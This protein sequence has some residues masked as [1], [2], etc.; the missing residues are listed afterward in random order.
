[1]FYLWCEPTIR[2][3][4]AL[5]FNA[6]ST[7]SHCSFFLTFLIGSR[8]LNGHCSRCW[9]TLSVSV[10]FHLRTGSIDGLKNQRWNRHIEIS[11]VPPNIVGFSIANLVWN[12]PV[13]SVV[14]SDPFPL[15][16]DTALSIKE[17]ATQLAEEDARH[18]QVAQ[19]GNEAWIYDHVMLC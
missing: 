11:F 8:M 18:S 17:R 5:L 6:L 4:L 16:C 9:A 3:V 14:L 7:L 12:L 13:V 15:E 19:T 10:N 1:M 2:L